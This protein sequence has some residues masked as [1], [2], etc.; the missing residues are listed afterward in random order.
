[1]TK[2]NK[3]VAQKDWEKIRKKKNAEIRKFPLLFYQKQD[4]V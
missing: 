1:M 2:I 4:S 3:Y